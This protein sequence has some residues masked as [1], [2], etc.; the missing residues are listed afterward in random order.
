MILVS[1]CKDFKDDGARVVAKSVLG[2]D[3]TPIE[4]RGAVMY[5]SE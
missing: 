4:R 5:T 3:R 2:S 1:E